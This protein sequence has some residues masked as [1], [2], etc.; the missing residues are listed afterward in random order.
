MARLST[1]PK[2]ALA[3]KDSIDAIDSQNCR[4]RLD[5]VQG[6]KKY[7]PSLYASAIYKLLFCSTY[8]KY[9]SPLSQRMGLELNENPPSPFPLLESYVRAALA[10]F[11]LLVTL[12]SDN[13]ATI[14]EFAHVSSSSSRPPTKQS[15]RHSLP[16]RRSWPQRL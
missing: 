4:I 6:A 10:L 11:T 1:T 8:N 12:A 7:G 2:D 5:T 13:I 15:P 16:H 14:V 9:M 3:N